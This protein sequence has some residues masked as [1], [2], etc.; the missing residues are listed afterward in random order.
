MFW[1]VSVKI[2]KMG[3]YAQKEKYFY[4]SWCEC[5]NEFIWK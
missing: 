3:F 1:K 4:T 5:S 2:E